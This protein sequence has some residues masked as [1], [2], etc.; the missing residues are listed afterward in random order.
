PE[1][2]ADLAVQPTAGSVDD[3]ELW[4]EYLRYRDEFFAKGI[5]VSDIPVAGRQLLTVV[6]A[7]GDPVLGATIRV[8]D[9]AGT[10]VATLRSYA[11]GR[12][13][14][15][16]GTDVDPSSQARPTYTAHVEARGGV[17]GTFALEPG[18][19][20]QTLTLDAD[21]PSPAQVDVLFLIDATG[22][23]GD[24]IERLKASMISV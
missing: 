6:D 17:A 12:A 14:F 19:L 9:E 20:A 2:P 11:D 15:L 3:N 5:P 22:S 8:T 24:E 13:V 1:A 23:M 16:A 10:T 18:G 4:D 7:D 21:V